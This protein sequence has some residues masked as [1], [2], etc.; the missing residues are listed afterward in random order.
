MWFIA[1]DWNQTDFDYSLAKKLAFDK[2]HLHLDDSAPVL[3]KIG[4]SSD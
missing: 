4:V 2:S 3:V 1:N